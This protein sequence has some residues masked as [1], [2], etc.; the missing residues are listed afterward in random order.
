M[1]ARDRFVK[2]REAVMELAQVQALIMTEGDDWKPEGAHSSGI[3]DPTANR[4]AYNVDTWADKLEELRSRES[5]LLDFIGLSLRI[6]EAVRDGLGDDYDGKNFA[7]VDASIVETHILLEIAD[8]GLATTWIGHF[9]PEKLCELF[10]D[11]NGY[12]LTALFAVGYAAEDASPAMA[13]TN[14]RSEYELIKRY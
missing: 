2:T 12:S 6:I 10:P 7:D 8:L 3:S 5:E 11:M 14:C 4:A 1:A 9:D 13:H